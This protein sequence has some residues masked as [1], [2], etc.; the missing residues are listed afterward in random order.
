MKPQC[1]KAAGTETNGVQFTG[2]LLHF[3]T[4]ILMQ[5]GF[6]KE[7]IITIARSIHTPYAAVWSDLRNAFAL[8]SAVFDLIP[9]G[10]YHPFNSHF[11]K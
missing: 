11:L 9:S 7:F 1:E 4:N 10:V 6:F 2:C 8:E 3:W 5:G